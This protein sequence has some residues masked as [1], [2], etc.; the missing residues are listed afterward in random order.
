MIFE[1]TATQFSLTISDSTGAVC[2]HESRRHMWKHF[3][4][5]ISES[6]ATQLLLAISESLG[7][8]CGDESLPDHWKPFR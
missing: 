4:M 7:A 1:A 5:M 3:L 6:A 2:S 8:V